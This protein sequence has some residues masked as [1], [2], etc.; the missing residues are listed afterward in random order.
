VARNGRMQVNQAEDSINL[1]RTG[2]HDGMIPAD[3]HGG[4]GYGGGGAGGGAGAG[5]ADGVPKAQLAQTAIRKGKDTIMINMEIKFP[6]KEKRKDKEKKKQKVGSILSGMFADQKFPEP[7]YFQNVDCVAIP[8]FLS[9]K[10]CQQI[11]DF[12]EASEFRNQHRYRAMNLSWVDIVD[13]Y[14]GEA[15]F[16]KCGL[17]WFLRSIVVD[18]MVAV[19]LNDV[20]RIH[21]YVQGNLFGRHID[22]VVQRADGKVS[23]YSLRVFLNGSDGEFEGGGSVFHIPFRADPVIFEPETGLALL[24]PQGDQCTV[25]EEAEVHFGAKYVLRADVLFGMRDT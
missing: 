4:G 19:G 12:A 23:R 14:F 10:E 18:G 13:P 11:I 17:A 6:Q 21:K 16:T 25:Q 22:Q 5:D 20:I 24:Y 2:A 7:L 3:V 1:V 8:F 15:M 9:K